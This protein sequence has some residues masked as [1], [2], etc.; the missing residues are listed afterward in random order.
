[1]SELLLVEETTLL[2]QTMNEVHLIIVCPSQDEATLTYN[3][4]ADEWRR[5]GEIRI[6]SKT[7]KGT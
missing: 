4:I 6:K 1:M 3:A 7:P 5:C 2:Q